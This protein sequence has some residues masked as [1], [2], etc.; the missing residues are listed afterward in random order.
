MRLISARRGTP[1]QWHQVGVAG[2]RSDVMLPRAVHVCASVMGRRD[3]SRR[4]GITLIECVIALTI[5]PLAVSAIAYAIVSGQMEEILSQPYADPQ[6]TVALGPDSG[7]TS[8]LLYDNM[9]DYHGLSETADNVK[10]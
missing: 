2:D 7:E 6:G 8:R 9:D 10:D 1:L 4:R 5:L 3:R